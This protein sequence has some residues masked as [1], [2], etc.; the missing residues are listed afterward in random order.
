MPRVLA[1]DTATQA[2]TLAL[3]DEQTVRA[4]HALEA[5]AHNRHVL[6]MLAE[7]LDGQ[8]LSDAVDVIACGVGPGSF[9]GL[10]VAG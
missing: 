3:W 4:R 5:R 7:V 2:C 9:T 10:R 1:L 6:T 8:R